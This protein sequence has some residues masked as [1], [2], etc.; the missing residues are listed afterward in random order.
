MTTT[1]RKRIDGNRHLLELLQ[2]GEAVSQL[3]VLDATI[4]VLGTPV[5]MGGIAGVGTRPE[6]RMKGQAR[7]LLEEA[8]RYMTGLGHDVSMLFGIPDFYDKF[9]FLPCLPSHC[10]RIATRDAERAAESAGGYSTRPIR[11]D[12]YSFVVRLYGEDNRNRP[13]ALVRDDRSFAGFPKGSGFRT[14]AACLILQDAKGTGVGYAAFDVSRTDVTVIEANCADPRAFHALLYEFAKM[15]VDRRA[16]YLELQMACDHPFV[17]FARRYGCE[18]RSTYERMASG[19]MRI[20]N[21]QALFRTLRP[22]LKKRLDASEFNGRS[23]KLTIETDLGATRLR[24]VN[25]SRRPAVQGAIRLGQ[26]RLTQIIVGYRRADD[27]L[28]DSSIAA[29]GD[30]VALLGALLGGQEPYVWKA[31]WF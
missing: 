28:T 27:L 19:M 29:E 10:V 15:A 4:R 23:V 30:A 20:L 24:F 2:D 16:G 12:D 1:I 25:R 9:G 17:R 11:Q 31:D 8:V 21:Q 26:D 3:T 7:R 6:H 22:A 5:R 13:A 18:V 14:P